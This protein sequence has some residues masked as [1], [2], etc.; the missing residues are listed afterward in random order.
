MPLKLAGLLVTSGAVPSAVVEDALRRQVLSGSALDTALFEAGAG[1]TEPQLLHRLEQASGL[2]GLG[3]AELLE[4]DPGLA[5]LLPAKLAERHCL[6]PLRSEGRVLEVA[7]RYP[8]SA[9]MLDQIGF[10]LRRE[11]HACVALEVRLREA[12]ARVYGGSPHPRFQALLQMLGPTPMPAD[13]GPAPRRETSPWIAGAPEREGAAASMSEE[14]LAARGP[15]APPRG[16]WTG[17]VEDHEGLALA[18]EHALDAAERPLRREAEAPENRLAPRGAFDLESLAER[19]VAISPRRAGREAEAP[20]EWTLANVRAAVDGTEDVRQIIRL[21]LRFALKTFDFAAA[22]AVVG[23]NAVGWAAQSPEGAADDDVER[24]SIPLDAPSVLRTVLLAK[25][26][27]LGPLPSDPLSQSLLAHLQRPEPPCAFLYAIEVRDRPVA[28]FYGDVIGRAVSD[29]D[30]GEFV[31][32]AQYL[33]QRIERLIVEQKR[34]LERAAREASGGRARGAGKGAVVEGGEA[35]APPAFALQPMLTTA[36]RPASG[37]PRPRGSARPSE[38]ERSEAVAVAAEPVPGASSRLMGESLAMPSSMD[39]LFSAAD[40]L[41]EADLGERAKALALLA[42]YPEV[43]AAVLVARFPGPVLRPRVPVAELPSPEELG[44]IPA[45]LA[46]MG[47]AAA[48]ALVPLFEH[49]HV[50]SR[51]FAVL[52]AGR[53]PAPILV[54]PIAQRVF[55]RHPVVAGAARVALASLRGV[56]GFEEAVARIRLALSSRDRETVSAAAKALGFLRDAAS[57]E[58]LIALTGHV[59][60]ALA[61]S[62]ADALRD[63]TKQHL[64]LSHARW[65]AWWEQAKLRPREEWLLEALRHED[66]EARASAAEEL[67]RAAGDGFGFSPGGPREEREAAVLRFEDWWRSRSAARTT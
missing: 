57:V 59:N 37:P 7:V 8:A 19:I 17:R 34:R 33:G 55:D 43:S 44:P 22:F 64:G 9:E 38:G 45:A 60:K 26:R 32:L 10:L 11:L 39:D 52:M 4:S 1:L 20:E 58:P 27:Y 47:L 49:R 53:L 2:P 65:A 66:F 30:V 12:L 42:R 56:Q 16:G 48:R 63:I 28:I 15:S 41:V 21:A 31:V 51:Y 35:A 23:G 36:G 3:A 13:E 5:R 18:I 54:G 67:A 50:D 62:A 46:R 40:R 14:V 61:L 24:I 29:F 25:G 6:L